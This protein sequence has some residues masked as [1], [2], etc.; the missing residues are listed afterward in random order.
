MH[1]ALQRLQGHI[2]FLFTLIG[3]T[4]KTQYF[5]NWGD[6]IFGFKDLL[7]GGDMDFNDAVFRLEFSVQGIHEAGGINCLAHKYSNF[8]TISSALS[9][10]AT[11]T[12]PRKTS[13]IL[14]LPLMQ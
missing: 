12:N 8:P 13:P 6:G 3:R 4:D 5:Q 9:T 2:C 1:R 14:K 11:K 7:G 10:S